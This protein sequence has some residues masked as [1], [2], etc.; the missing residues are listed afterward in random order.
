MSEE[1]KKI[2]IFSGFIL[3]GIFLGLMALTCIFW[4]ETN[5][6]QKTGDKINVDGIHPA[7]ERIIHTNVS[8]VFFHKQDMQSGVSENF[9]ETNDRYF[10]P[11]D[12][13]KMQAEVELARVMY[14]T[15]QGLAATNF[16][17]VTLYSDP[18]SV[19]DN[20][21]TR[22]QYYKFYAGTRGFKNILLVIPA[23]KVMGFSGLP[24]AL[25]SSDDDSVRINLRKTQEFY[26]ANYPGSDIRS[27]KLIASAC[28][29][30][31]IQMDLVLPRSTEVM[32]VFLDYGTPRNQKSCKRWENSSVQ[33]IPDR[34]A[35]WENGD[36]YYRSVQ[37]AAQ[38]QGINLTE[39]CSSD[40]RDTMKKILQ[41]IN[42]PLISP[43]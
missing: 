21:G 26:D 37:E 8:D 22:P 14:T 35:E 7:P 17:E 15:S 36:R 10:I 13:G 12:T 6:L 18:L 5:P 28:W 23:S 38:Y 29:G 42:P 27:I 20:S 30:E 11:F 1:K 24:G 9:S 4:Q 31:I 39:P 34:I 43:R 19:Y 16:S 25:G 32:T 2:N 41:S 3:L 40:K 33:A